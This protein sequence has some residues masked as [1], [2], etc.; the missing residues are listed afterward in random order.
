MLLE[1][2]LSL[3]DLLTATRGTVSHLQSPNPTP[4]SRTRQR[5]VHTVPHFCFGSDPHAHVLRI[6]HSCEQGPDQ[7]TL[8]GSEKNI[9]FLTQLQLPTAQSRVGGPF[10]LQQSPFTVLSGGAAQSG[11]PLARSR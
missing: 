8:A 9:P 7:V 2:W 1:A 4:Q 6:I 3:S 10:L 5:I 11:D